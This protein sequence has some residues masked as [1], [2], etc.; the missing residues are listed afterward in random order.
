MKHFPGAWV[1]PGGHLEPN[2]DLEFGALRELREETGIDIYSND[3]DGIYCYNGSSVG[4]MELFYAFEKVVA[5]GKS[6][7]DSHML[8]LFFKI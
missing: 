1:I 4:P 6:V 5:S 8:I 7:P 2:E 3:N